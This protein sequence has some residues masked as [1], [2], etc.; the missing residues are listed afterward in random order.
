[1]K[2]KMDTSEKLREAL[3]QLEETRKREQQERKISETLLEGLSAIV[4]AHDPDEIFR[5]LLRI[6]REPLGFEEAFMLI[7]RDDGTLTASTSSD[8]IFLDMVWQPGAMFKRIFAGQPAAIYNTKL[9]PEWRSQPDPVKRISRSA[10]H[11]TIHSSRPRAMF[12]CTHSQPA[13]FSRQ[14]VLLAQRFSILA[15]QALRQIEFSFEIADL[16]RAEKQIKHLNIVQNALRQINRLIRREKDKNLLLKASCE[17]LAG[18]GCYLNVWITLTDDKQNMI[19]GFESGV[20]ASVNPLTPRLRQG[21]LTGREKKIMGE[22]GVSL[23]E[24]PPNKRGDR[25]RAGQSPGEGTLAVKLE[26]EV[27]VFGILSASGPLEFFQTG[28][29]QRL[30]QEIADDIAFALFSLEIRDNVNRGEKRIEELNQYLHEIF[31]TVPDPIFVKERNHRWIFLNDAFCEFI[32]YSRQEVIGKSDYDFFPKEEADVFWKKDEMVFHTGEININE[33]EFTTASGETKTIVTKKSM[34]TRPDGSQ[35]LVGVI[36]D[37]TASKQAE[38]ELRSSEAQKQ[39]ILDGI[40]TNLAFV[41]DKLEILW[42]NKCAA[43]S[44]GKIPGEMIGHKCYEL[45]AN[46]EKPCENCPIIKAF[47]T[48]KTEHTL[49][50]TPDGRIWDE[51]GEPVLDQY[52]EVSGVVEIA[53][54]ITERHLADIRLRESEEK[55]RSYVDNAPDGIFI[56]DEEGNYLEVNEAAC[57]ITGYSREE[58]LSMS[59]PDIMPPGMEISGLERFNRLKE[60]GTSIG[61]G[62]YL[63]KNGEIRYWAISA[64]KLQAHR[65]MGFTSDITEEH[66]NREELL[67]YREKLE[68]LVNE[69]TKELRERVTE[70]ERFHDAMVGREIRIK[71]LRDEVDLLRTRVHPDKKT[72]R[73]HE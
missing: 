57:W 47:K 2:N 13:H 26:H 61:E 69:R 46:P 65:F 33:E 20:R 28:E 72:D 16:K 11:F 48:G 39:A 67:K 27:R 18:E 29:E 59:I 60:E 62:A 3:L 24:D 10:L 5:E 8:P 34:F 49:I 23:S 4:Q 9:V 37:V 51:S 53:Q 45:W 1:M 44:V 68:E 73:R 36:R 54:D 66:R 55:Y 41:N 64:V 6:L 31:N 19:D 22:R 50:T 71:E 63:H 30:F 42:A 21:D 7:E 40:T 32:G 70:L 38:A 35:I 15:T 17:I 58:L 12:V 25:P 56:T 43:D 14:H 52:G